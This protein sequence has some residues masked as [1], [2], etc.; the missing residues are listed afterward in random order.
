[1]WMCLVHVDVC[2]YV[3][4]WD[5]C[6]LSGCMAFVEVCCLCGCV[7][8]M[9]VCCLCIYFVFFSVWLIFPCFIVLFWVFYVFFFDLCVFANV[10]TCFP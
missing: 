1:M 4:L 8:Y 10:C 5:V 6:C 3:D 2:V 9:D 7:G